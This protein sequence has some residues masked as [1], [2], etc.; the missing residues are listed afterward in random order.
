[1]KKYL[2]LIYKNRYLIVLI[3][4]LVIATFIYFRCTRGEG[5]YLSIQK[6]KNIGLTAEEITSIKNIGQWEF[7]SMTTEEMTDT[8]RKQL[9]TDDRLVRIYKGTLRLGINLKKLP[10]DW[11]NRHGDTVRLKLPPI[12]LLDENFIDEAQTTTFYEHGRWSSQAKNA[13][14]EKAK[15]SMIKRIMTT[16]HIKEADEAAKE[17]FTKLMQA[18]GFETVEFH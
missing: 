14:Y 6:E 16:E 5:T 8:I 7:L 13:M 15:K 10:E 1:M 17:Q 18:Y 3:A 2:L 12:E 4:M 9:V 11:I